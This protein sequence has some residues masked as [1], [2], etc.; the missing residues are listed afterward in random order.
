MSRLAALSFVVLS[1][2]ATAAAPTPYGVVFSHPSAVI[3]QSAA[4]R[5]TTEGAIESQARVFVFFSARQ[6]TSIV[7]VDG[8]RIAVPLGEG[9]WL[10]AT[11]TVSGAVVG[12]EGAI[13]DDHSLVGSRLNSVVVVLRADGSF[14]VSARTGGPIIQDAIA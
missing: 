3:G 13:P 7:E 1:I 14:F 9:A 5:M 2:S 12:L 6:G 10:A 4:V 11:S 8:Q